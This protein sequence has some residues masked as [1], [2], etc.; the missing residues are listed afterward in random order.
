ML[1]LNNAR[2]AE[3]WVPIDSVEGSNF[4]I[5]LRRPTFQ[6]QT[7]SIMSDNRA[8]YRIQSIVA[9]WRGV[10]DADGK[11]VPF[12]MPALQQLCEVHPFALMGILRA[13]GD[14]FIGFSEAD[15]KN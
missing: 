5:L 1:T 2:P 12:T 14:A 6:Q 3:K 4:D 11:E 13:V 15:E 7:E 10:V 9:G 8:A